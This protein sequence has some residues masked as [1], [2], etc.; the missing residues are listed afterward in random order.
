MSDR[1]RKEEMKLNFDIVE[2]SFKFYTQR[3]IEEIDKILKSN[4]FTWQEK[5]MYIDKLPESTIKRWIGNIDELDEYLADYYPEYRYM[6]Y[7]YM[8][9][10]YMYIEQNKY[11]DL[12]LHEKSFEELP[13]EIQQLLLDIFKQKSKG[14]IYD[15]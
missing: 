2:N 12:E 10:F 15:W 6:K 13:E 5:L 11:Y 7:D 8:D 1:D 9:L 3:V 4:L 14:F